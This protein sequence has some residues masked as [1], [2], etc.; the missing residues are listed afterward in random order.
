MAFCVSLGFG[1][2]RGSTLNRK[3]RGS[4]L[5]VTG[6][7]SGKAVQKPVTRIRSS[8]STCRDCASVLV[9]RGTDA[10]RTC[11]AS[12]QLD[13]LP[14]RGAQAVSLV[15]SHKLCEDYTQRSLIL[16]CLCWSC[17]GASQPQTSHC[18]TLVHGTMIRSH[19]LMHIPVAATEGVMSWLL[20]RARRR[21]SDFKRWVRLRFPDDLHSAREVAFWY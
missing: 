9:M 20:A 10:C 19:D 18:L 11:Y 5:G 2:V 1:S 17:V 13:V 4:S 8:H 15:R 7:A 21:S 14:R 16:C 12:S 6:Q 3:L